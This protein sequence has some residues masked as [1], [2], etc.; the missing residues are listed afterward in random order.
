MSAPAP[1]AGIT[2][3]EFTHMVMGPAV[4]HI[5]A[6]LGAEVVRVEPIGGDRTRRLMGSGA[7]Y[8]PMYNR[9]KQ[10]ICLDLKSE[11]GLAVAKDLIAGAD[12]LVENFRPGALDRLGL[13]YD[14]CA[15]A[16]PRLIYCSEKGFLPGPYENRTALDEVAQ[17]MGGLAYMTGPPGQPLRA[18]ASVID[19]TG[20]M[21]GVIGVLAALEE[22]HRTGKGQK[23]TASLFETTIYL[24][25]QHMAQ[26]AVTGTPAAPMPAR[27]SAWA[28]YDVFETRDDPVFIGVVTDALWEK[29]CALFGLDELWADESLRENNA[30]VQARDRIMPVIRDLVGGMTAAEVIAK[31]DGSGLPFAPIG[32]PEDMFD[33]PH[34]NTGGLEDVT[35]DNG[36][37]V[38]LPT[39]PLEMGGHRIGAPQH[40]P[41]PGRDARA[42]LAG[43]GYGSARI[44]ALIEGG[45]VGESE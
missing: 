36:T 16:N 43:L 14:S 32:K 4:G 11:E 10:S 5:L 37:P 1:L 13:D 20:G 40:L 41:Q 18:G 24:V 25:G 45:A 15:T 6:G 33:D 26:Y 31:L 12:I 21:F 30:R 8:F 42:V 23:V 9:G 3:V 34:L 44:D 29:F 2:V 38:R 28:I 27:V 7:G 22:R 39:I 19:V 17:M 35:L